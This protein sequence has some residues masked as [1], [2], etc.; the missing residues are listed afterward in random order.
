[1]VAVNARIGQFAECT[2]VVDGRSG[3]SEVRLCHIPSL[4]GDQVEARDTC[5]ERSEIVTG[6]CLK[7][8]ITDHSGIFSRVL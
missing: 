6:G 2:S 7:V 8:L 1:M 4:L 5:S 3:R